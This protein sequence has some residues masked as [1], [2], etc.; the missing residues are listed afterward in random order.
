MSWL[1]IN[2]VLAVAILTATIG[3][4]A[5]AIKTSYRDTLGLFDPPFRE[6][7]REFYKP[8]PPPLRRRTAAVNRL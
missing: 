7:V 4:L 6:L 1:I 8:T 5:W 3:V 2:L